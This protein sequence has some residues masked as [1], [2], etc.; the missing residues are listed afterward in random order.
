MGKKKAKG[1]YNDFLDGEKLRDNAGIR[2]SLDPDSTVSSLQRDVSPPP[3]RNDARPDQ[4]DRGPEGAGKGTETSRGKG[5]SKKGAAAGKKPPLTHF[6]CLPLVNT[7]SRPSLDS[8]LARL[9]EE[10]IRSGAV[11]EK[12]VRPVGT[13]H[14]T[15]GVMSLDEVALERVGGCLSD[16]ELDGL[17][18]K[19]GVEDG[20]GGGGRSGDGDG[21]GR[22]LEL[23]VDLKGL[24]PMQ[25]PHKT[26]ILYAEPVDVGGKG[27]SAKLYGFAKVLKERFEKEGFMVKEDRKLRLHATVINT[28]YAK[29][30]GGRRKRKGKGKQVHE[31]ERGQVVEQDAG[32]AAEQGSS[33][34]ESAVNNS[35]APPDPSTA[36]TQI[37]VPDESVV[38]SK[39]VDRSEGHGPNAKS[40]MRFDAT[41]L[42]K[43]YE[44]FTWADG[45][46]IDRVQ[47]CKMGAK[48]ILDEEGEVVDERYEVVFERMIE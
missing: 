26:S 46:K 8:G 5:K 11:P 23:K 37:P 27:A 18:S 30:K 17:M 35:T 45:V 36:E 6:L 33:N 9:K 19:G 41:G 20:S 43:D 21:D 28:V 2:T 22:V 14:L 12:A 42:I 48:K 40:W 39:E 25:Q 16:L 7:E 4:Q 15:L 29:P 24:V 13:L 10:L 38:D 47:V 1:D 34:Q 31:G 3:P 32:H 44:N